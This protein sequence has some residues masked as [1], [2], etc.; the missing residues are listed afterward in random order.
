MELH[1]VLLVKQKHVKIAVLANTSM[2]RDRL[3]Y[4]TVKI[5]LVVNIVKIQA[6]SMISVVLDANQDNMVAKQ[7]LSVN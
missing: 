4:K 2:K 1:Q 7:V 3:Q 5:A 6:I